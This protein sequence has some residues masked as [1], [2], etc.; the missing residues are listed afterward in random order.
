MNDVSKIELGIERFIKEPPKWLK[1]ARLGLLANQASVDRHFEQA[2]TLLARSFPGRLTALLNPQHGFHGEK[3]DNMIESNHGH[4]PV[5]NIPIFSLYGRTRKPSKEMFDPI[6]ILL[7]DLQDVGTRVYTFI[8]TLAYCMEAARQ[9]DK[10]V[11]VLDRPNPIGGLLTEGNLLKDDFRSFVGLFPIPMRHGLTIG[12]VASLWREAYGL[13]CDLEVMPMRGWRREMLFMDTRLPWVMP[14]PNMPTPDTALVY[15]GQVVW[16]GT[17]ISEGRGTTRPFELFGAPF[18][19]P[20]PLKDRFSKRRIDGVIL[21]EVSFQPTFHKWA[22]HVCSGF[23]L[24]VT[25]VRT[26][27]PYYT[28]LCLLQDTMSLYPD[29]FSWREPPYE[30]EYE[31]LPIDLILG[32]DSVRRALEE[33]ADLCELT[34]S[35]DSHLNSFEA[36]RQQFFLYR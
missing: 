36:L 28:S 24:H 9:W 34:A 31:K 23:Q 22:G 2:A 13:D 19:E 15:P 26:Y 6:D 27:K 25:D 29:A 18:I 8:Y 33:G 30:Y 35:W 32:D 10:K 21:R 1:G 4:D 16:E 12:E 17:N 20:G 11:V 3:Q 14:S 5:L 7:V